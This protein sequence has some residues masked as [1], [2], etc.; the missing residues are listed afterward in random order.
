MENE[1]VGEHESTQAESCVCREIT[2]QLAAMFGI[3]SE[4]ARKHLRNA[5]IEVLKAVRSVIDERI[6]YLSHAGNK[7]TKVPVE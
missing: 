4:E 3:K 7:G 6:E 1:T 2:H 5:R